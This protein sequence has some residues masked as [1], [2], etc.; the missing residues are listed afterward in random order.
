MIPTEPRLDLPFLILLIC[1]IGLS[2]SCIYFIIRANRL[3]KELE[4]HKQSEKFFKI[5]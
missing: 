1:A 5:T 2:I 3:E 4:K